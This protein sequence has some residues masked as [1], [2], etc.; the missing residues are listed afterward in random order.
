MYIGILLIVIGVACFS[1]T[2]VKAVIS[3][4]NSAKGLPIVITDTTYKIY[5]IF[6]AVGVIVGIV[7]LFVF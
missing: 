7:L 4:Q 6:G 3:V 5:R 2:V 1:K